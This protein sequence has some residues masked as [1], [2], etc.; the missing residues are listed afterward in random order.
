M[1]LGTYYS[2]I[3]GILGLYRW[4]LYGT[5]Y[6]PAWV[7]STWVL[8]MYRYIWFGTHRNLLHGV[9]SVQAIEMS[10]DSVESYPLSV[11]LL[12]WNC[13]IQYNTSHI[14]R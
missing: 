2:T 14:F 9:Q 1:Y 8:G 10:Q 11:L 3:T 6:V 4:I 13:L 5:F 12:T 7:L